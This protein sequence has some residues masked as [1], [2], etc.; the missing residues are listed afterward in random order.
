M[1]RDGQ[2]CGVGVGQELPWPA[3]TRKPHATTRLSQMGGRGL[4]WCSR[5]GGGVRARLLAG[6]DT[7]RPCV[8]LRR[9]RLRPTWPRHP[10]RSRY[11]HAGGSPGKH[12]HG[13]GRVGCCSGRR[14]RRTGV[15]VGKPRISLV[16]NDYQIFPTPLS[17][18]LQAFGGHKAVL[19]LIGRLHSA[20]V[21]ED[22]GLWTW[23]TRDYGQLGHGDDENQ[24]HL[25]RVQNGL[26]G[27]RVWMVSCGAYHT[28]VVTEDCGVS[29]MGNSYHGCLG[30]VNLF[31]F[32]VLTRIN[33]QLFGGA[34]MV[35][36]TAGNSF[37]M[38]VSG[39]GCVYWWGRDVLGLGHP[40][41][42]PGD[43]THST[44]CERVAATSLQGGRVVR[45]KRLPRENKLA[46]VMGSHSALGRDHAMTGFA[47]TM[48]A[49]ILQKIARLSVVPHDGYSALLHGMR[50]LVVAEPAGGSV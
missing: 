47:V 40:P 21:T 36:V 38:A 41:W 7:G 42:Q 26:Q 12:H 20:V 44:P 33:P 45:A 4:R 43:G 23:G 50:R 5:G 30:V 18:D 19:V 49:E 6:A 1:L 11:S 46:F 2:R 13:D 3:G 25:V 9:I 35:S 17:M 27:S 16:L 10:R 14:G 22:G 34:Q 28:L 31:G 15:D 29:A 8:E 37:S 39:Q 24:L 48:P 32:N